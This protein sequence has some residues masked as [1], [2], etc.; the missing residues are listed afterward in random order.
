[1]DVAREPLLIGNALQEIPKALALGFGEGGQERV[2]MFA[3]DF[4]DPGDG[5]PTFF[6][7][8]QFVAAAVVRADAPL[9]QA[10]GIEFVEQGHQPAGHQSK[11]VREGLL[12]HPR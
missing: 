9:R 3:G 2:L 11:A 12:R 6:G 5:L 1:M 8:E 7:H 10:E 4:A